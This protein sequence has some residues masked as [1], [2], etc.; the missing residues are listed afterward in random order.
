MAAAVRCVCLLSFPRVAEAISEMNDSMHQSRFW[1]FSLAVYGDTAV[2]RECLDLQDRYDVDVNLLLLCA[3]IGSVH[4]AVLP[5][6][7]L[8]Q[9]AD[10]VS[11]WHTKIVTNLREARRALKPF[12]TD[13]SSIAAA[14]GAVR[15]NVKAMELEAERVEQTMLEDWTASRLDAWPRIRAAEAV[16]VNIRALFALGAGSAGEPGLPHRLI[17]AAVAAGH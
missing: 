8:R 14:A 10:L 13:A 6:R 9:A 17:A 3:F 5:A 15:R 12:T 4:G 1:A 11:E 2:Q 16:A 7:D